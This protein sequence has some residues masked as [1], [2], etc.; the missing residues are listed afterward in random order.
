[1]KKLLRKFAVV[2]LFVLP[3]CKQAQAQ[4]SVGP[5]VGFTAAGL[6]SNE[7]DVYAG[8]NVHAGVYRTYSIRKLSCGKAINFI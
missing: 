3:F 1:M 7:D 6:Y 5:E 8:I 4:V 2:L